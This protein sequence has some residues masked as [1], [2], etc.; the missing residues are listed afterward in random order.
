MTVSQ[1]KLAKLLCLKAGEIWTQ[2]HINTMGGFKTSAGILFQ[3][4]WSVF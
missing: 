1:H 4:I 2:Q 3:K